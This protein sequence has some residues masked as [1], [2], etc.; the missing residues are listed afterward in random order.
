LF[1]IVLFSL[2]VFLIIL[3]LREKKSPLLACLRFRCCPCCHKQ[4]RDR[5]LW[6]DNQAGV[7]KAEQEETSR[8]DYIADALYY[9]NNRAITSY[10]LRDKSLHCSAK[11][12]ECAFSDQKTAMV[13]SLQK[14]LE[15]YYMRRDSKV[16][17]FLRQLH[18]ELRDQEAALKSHNQYLEKKA[19]AEVSQETSATIAGFVKRKS[20][21]NDFY[22]QNIT[23][24]AKHQR[25]LLERAWDEI[26]NLV[27]ERAV[28]R[29]ITLDEQ[30]LGAFLGGDGA[31]V[32][33]DAVAK[34]K[35]NDAQW[36]RSEE[37]KSTAMK[38][39][40][41]VQLLRSGATGRPAEGTPGEQDI[42][43]AN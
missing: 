43:S 5:P 42:E 28:K 41:V 17:T 2:G 20:P 37:E 35:S 27:R 11:V 16:W 26:L 33:H 3:R 38:L 1:F 23:V 12:L 6:D 29:K 19:S 4:L 36:A 39:D 22:K 34:T 32:V 15:I 13:V 21:E 40:E 10:K 7:K 18:S 25:K 9:P 24:L 8:E 30:F 31:K 14:P